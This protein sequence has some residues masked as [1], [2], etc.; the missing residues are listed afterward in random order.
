V[1]DAVKVISAHLV[2]SPCKILLLCHTTSTY[3][4]SPKNCVRWGP[5]PLD[6]AW[7]KVKVKVHAYT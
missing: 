3:V 1:V 6:G 4:G 5:A 2:R 7:L